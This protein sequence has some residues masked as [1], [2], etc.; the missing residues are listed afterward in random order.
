MSVSFTGT[1]G[2]A[3]QGILAWNASNIA[4]YTKRV[5]ANAITML[6]FGLGNIAGSYTFPEEQAPRYQSGKITIMSCLAAAIV[7]S[8][9]LK[10]INIFYNRRNTRI[11]EAMEP[12][13]RVNKEEE[14]A[15]A[16]ET[17]MRNPFFRYTY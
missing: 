11:V 4:G 17:D 15:F 2:P 10:L 3:F 8:T 12:A 7:M 16:D 5:S 13:E 6:M 14:M 1:F 9:V